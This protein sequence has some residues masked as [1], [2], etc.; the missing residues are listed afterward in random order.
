MFMSKSKKRRFTITYDN[1]RGGD[2]RRIKRKLRRF[3][4]VENV[5]RPRTTVR[6]EPDSKIEFAKIKQALIASLD[7]KRGSA[8]ISSRRTG[9]EYRA[10]NRGNR[11]GEFVRE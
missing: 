10:D 3:G 6:L 4:S 1:P 7:P 5:R 9:N 11:P 2:Y 8:L